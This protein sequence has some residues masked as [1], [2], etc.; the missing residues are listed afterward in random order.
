[1]KL[2]LIMLVA[3]SA[4]AVNIQEFPG[5]DWCMQVN[6]A[7]SA[8][9]GTPATLVVPSSVSGA[10]GTQVKLSS[11][12]SLHFGPGTFNLGILSGR[13]GIL[14]DHGISNVSITGEGIGST[15]LMFTSF[16]IGAGNVF[17]WGSAIGIGT[18]TSCASPSDPSNNI[19]IS[20]ITFS[21][22]Q[23]SSGLSSAHNPSIIDGAC[24]N[25]I[26]IEHNE[27]TNAK[28]NA[29]V[30]VAGKWNTQ[31]GLNYRNLY[32]KYDGTAAGNWGE[33]AADN[34]Y[35]FNNIWWTGNNVSGYKCSAFGMSGIFRASVNDNLIDQTLVASACAAIGIGADANIGFVSVVN[36]TVF[37]NGNSVGPCIQ[38]RPAGSSAD[39][40][41]DIQNNRCLSLGGT[42][43]TGTAGIFL[44]GVSSG[45]APT[46]IVRGNYIDAAYPI[47]VSAPL[48]GNVEISDNLMEDVGKDQDILD[49]AGPV[50]IIVG[51]TIRVYENKI[52]AGQ[53]ARQC[54][55]PSFSSPA[56]SHWKNTIG[57]N[58]E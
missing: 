52:N 33:F 24:V 35:N 54:T 1:M 36:N 50:S 18:V 53:I 23:T 40:V 31:G 49:C 39:A 28:G 15:Q 58:T 57:L 37:I 26:T 6:A 45:A 29:A 11:N 46:Q 12:H 9:A 27:F 2:I 20:G 22:Q 48:I 25:D 32:N 14:I 5:T 38:T 8:L 3:V 17:P 42:V 41:I 19:S 47:L 13:S 30:T 7:D 34:S 51:S 43:G 44:N 55:D 16:N 21:D 4:S 10:C 56:F